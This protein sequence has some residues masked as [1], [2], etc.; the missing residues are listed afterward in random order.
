[1]A[2]AGRAGW[3][4]QANENE[5]PMTARTHQPRTAWL[6]LLA[7]CV[8]TLSIAPAVAQEQPEDD[9]RRILPPVLALLLDDETPPPALVVPGAGAV[10][11]VNEASTSF[12]RFSRD[13]SDEE[14]AWMRDNYLRMITFSPY[15]D[16]RL[17]WYPDAWLNTN[18]SGI[19]VDGTNVNNPPAATL[20]DANG[21][22]LYLAIDCDGTS[23][24]RYAA[25]VGDPAFRAAWI[26][27]TRRVLDR[28]YGGLWMDYVNLSLQTVNANGDK[29]PAIDPRTGAEM[30][31]E[32]WRRYFAEFVEQV[33]DAFPDQ[34]ITH[35]V[36]WFAGP[37]T[38][39]DPYVARQIAAA[40]YVGL[41]RGV[42]DDGLTP[43]GRFSLDSYLGFNDRVH[44]LGRPVVTAASSAD[45]AMREY[46]LAGAL[47]TAGSADLFSEDNRDWTVRGAFWAGYQLDLGA[48][49]TDRY[50][51]RGVWRR[52]YDCGTVL[53]NGPGRSTRSL[54]FDEGFTTI[55][56]DP[57]DRVVLPAR[58]GAVLVS[59]CG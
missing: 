42:N 55:D 11:F 17:E 7:C 58:S 14:Q 35:S 39:D 20:R 23:C 53:L 36:Q 3:I 1:M 30:V 33:R 28:G 9:A 26:D 49:V 51:W 45:E 47:L 50:R 15:F 4:R 54:G 34:E 24:E 13:P 41:A 18:A 12:D 5:G 37:A 43:R 57:V 25:D 31:P 52:D 46:S 27:D 32:D 38:N 56:G 2:S 21:N 6:R 8:V 44:A 29:V 59:D 48:S 40:T 19:V 22:P 16:K 10:R